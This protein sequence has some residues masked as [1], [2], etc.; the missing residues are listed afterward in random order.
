MQSDSS[1]PEQK[2]KTGDEFGSIVITFSRVKIVRESRLEEP[3]SF[4]KERRAVSEKILKGKAISHQT[5][6][7]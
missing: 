2:T 7:V 4:T 5:T 1:I 3:H 6:W